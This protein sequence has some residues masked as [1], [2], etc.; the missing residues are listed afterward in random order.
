MDFDFFKLIN[1]S[2]TVSDTK[3]NI[4]YMND[5]AIDSLGNMVGKNMIGC[6]NTN[7]QQIINCLL[8]DKATNVYTIEK[9]GVKKLIYQT[10]WYNEQKEL[11]GLIEFSF[12]VPFEMPHHKR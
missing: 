4:L 1:G 9:K 7:S 10:P 5:K 3:G 8:T 12:A 2:I 11:G 6:H